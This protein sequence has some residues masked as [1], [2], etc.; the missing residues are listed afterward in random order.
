MASSLRPTSEYG[1]VPMTSMRARAF[2]P[3]PEQQAGKAA[4]RGY[5]QALRDKDYGA[6][7][8]FAQARGEIGDEGTLGSYEERAATDFL[9]REAAS[10]V[11]SEILGASRAGAQRPVSGTPSASSMDPGFRPSVRGASGLQGSTGLQGA[12]MRGAPTSPSGP[13]PSPTV[14]QPPPAPGASQVPEN[15][16]SGAKVPMTGDVR[17][18]LN[19][20]QL[21]SVDEMEKLETGGMMRRDAVEEVNKRRIASGQAPIAAKTVIDMLHERGKA[22][23]PA[24][25][26][27][28]NR[29]SVTQYAEPAGPEN[30]VG[31]ILDP[32]MAGPVRPSTAAAAATPTTTPAV[33]PDVRSRMTARFQ[34]ASPNEILES[35]I[36]TGDPDVVS[37]IN[38]SEALKKRTA[39]ENL[40]RDIKDMKL[41]SK[42]RQDAV[43]DV[44][45]WMRGTM[46]GSALR[47]TRRFLAQ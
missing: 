14:A 10:A 33:V 13:V 35:R 37:D 19:A 9:D 15:P 30:R 42:A 22:R 29:P 32:R 27:P 43:S 36:R 18:R 44:P 21:A 3:S 16:V 17:T 34:P 41:R 40:N 1:R 12:R 11:T 8:Q 26:G 6:A 31:V 23:G 46:A 25:L 2:G 28:E 20:R 5:R 39:A 7:M 24:V 4:R 45:D 47:A 38:K